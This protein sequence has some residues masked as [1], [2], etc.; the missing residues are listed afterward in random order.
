MTARAPANASPRCGPEA[1]TITVG[2]LS[3]DAADAVLD[4]DRAQAVALGLLGGD[5]AQQR[6]GHLGVG[7]V[8]E[9]RRPRG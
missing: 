8:V 2:S 1:A 3:G 7:L 4:G 6:L 9:V 5:R